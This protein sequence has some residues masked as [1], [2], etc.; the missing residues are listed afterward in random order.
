MGAPIESQNVEIKELR[1]CTKE[2]TTAVKDS[3]ELVDVTDKNMDI[4]LNN[5]N[6]ANKKMKNAY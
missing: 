1:N 4:A 3:S 6:K 2:F 5:V